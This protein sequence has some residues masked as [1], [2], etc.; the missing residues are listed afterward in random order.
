LLTLFF[1]ST[2]FL[3]LRGCF[4]DEISDTFGDEEICDVD[5]NHSIHYRVPAINWTCFD[6]LQLSRYNN[7]T[8]HFNVFVF[9][10]LQFVLHQN[11]FREQRN[12]TKLNVFRGK[13]SD[14]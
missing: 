14:L 6:G 2:V 9:L 8:S 13:L 1:Y 3:L 11:I 7:I 4:G 5:P 10:S 12:E